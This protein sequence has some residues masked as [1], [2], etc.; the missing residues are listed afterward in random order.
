M[1]LII[2][3]TVV[4]S[5]GR[6]GCVRTKAGGIKCYLKS[7]PEKGRANKELV[8]TLAKKLGISQAEVEIIGGLTNRSKRLRISGAL[9]HDQVMDRL[10]VARQTSFV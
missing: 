1:T 5:S 8:K 7:A 4:P 3:L 9:T 6:T 2:T 10:G